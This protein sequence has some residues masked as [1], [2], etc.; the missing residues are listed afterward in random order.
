MFLS[1]ME[2]SHS[3]KKIAGR[4]MREDGRWFGKRR[5]NWQHIDGKEGMADLP[6]RLT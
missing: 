2:A 5:A 6:A 3:Q 4:E 1:I